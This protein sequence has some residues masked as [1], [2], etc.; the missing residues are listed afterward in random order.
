MALSSAT[1]ILRGGLWLYLSS[2][3]NNFFGFIFWLT[4]SAIAGPNVLG[5]V[6][7]VIGLSSMVMNLT[8]LGIPIGMQR[9]LGMYV[10]RRELFAEFFWSSTLLLLSIELTVAVALTAMVLMG[11][12]ILNF[13]APMIL[14]ASLMTV[15]SALGSCITSLLVS[16]VRTNILTLATF[17]GNIAKLVL[18]TTLVLA[19]F[20]WV[21]AAIAYVAIPLAI[22]VI[23]FYSSR[24]LIWAR[25]R[26]DL[27][28]AKEVVKAGIA[29]WIPNTI[30]VLGQQ[31]AILSVF[32]AR[33]AV[34]TGLLYLALTIAGFI[35]AIATSMLSLLLPVLSSMESGRETLCSYAIRLSLSL[36]TPIA[37]AIALYP[38]LPLSLL[39]KSYVEASPLLRMV[40]PSVLLLIPTSAIV[41]LFYSY[42]MYRRVA[43]A[44]TLSSG[45][46]VCLYLALVPIYGASGAAIAYTLGAAAPI[47]YLVY[48]ARGMVRVEPRHILTVLL[49]PSVTALALHLLNAPWYVGI[50]LVLASYILYTR[51][52]AVT[53]R[54]LRIV[55][56]SF[57]SSETIDSV[58]RRLKPL[59]DVVVPQ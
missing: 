54:D 52:G 33:G 44:G 16:L 27:D 30:L 49:V 2:V 46:R 57:V 37:V 19:G 55:A 41:N 32:G 38:S 9:F 35:G 47:P 43:V 21:G 17:I 53:R 28:K 36:A 56:Q 7:A 15:V 12:P 26:L 58:Y 42:G 31:L 18:G 6:S 51:L 45:V 14:V 11:I 34:E 5:V 22:V 40:M 39:G 50:P 4:I 10:S 29:S 59:I 3:V 8:S 20:G 13:S 23:G 24:T 25:P 48:T 1:K